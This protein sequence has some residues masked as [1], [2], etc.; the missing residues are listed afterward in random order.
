MSNCLFIDKAQKVK[1]HAQV[2][3]AKKSGL[4]LM[5]VRAHTHTH[6]FPDAQESSWASSVQQP[7]LENEYYR[8]GHK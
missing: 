2:H 1:R 6:T 4:K 5:H 8:F 7:G 3:T